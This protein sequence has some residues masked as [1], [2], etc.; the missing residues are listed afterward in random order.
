[1]RILYL[2]Y[3][4]DPKIPVF[5]WQREI[6]IELAKRGHE[7]HVISCQGEPI[8]H[9]DFHSIF[10]IPDR[11]LGLN[12]RTGGALLAN[13]PVLNHVRNLRP[14]VLFCHMA[15]EWTWRLWPTFRRL[16]CPVVQWYAHGTT[17]I[18]LRLAA[19]V[20]DTFLT[21]TESGCRVKHPDIRVI[22]QGI[23]FATF[24]LSDDPP[25]GTFTIGIVGRIS[26]TKRVTESIEACEM[27]SRKLGQPV[28]VFVIGSGMNEIEKRY[29]LKVRE[30]VSKYSSDHFSVQVVGNV[31]RESLAS[32]YQKCHA[33]VNLSSTGSL[34]KTIVEAAAC[35]TPTATSNPAAAQLLERFPE[36]RLHLPQ[37]D[38]LVT[39]LGEVRRKLLLDPLA[40]RSLRNAAEMYSLEHYLDEVERALRGQVVR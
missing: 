26:P 7:M 38:A 25:T 18:N 39:S 17:G 12:R 36:L 40:Y 8:S 24:S 2:T 34:D 23:N 35:G 9:P 20:V 4:V 11:V 31:P 22:G 5:S 27:L 3:S 14:D 29:E 19:R 32:W 33:V 28:R 10:R 30:S 16:S 21:S 37:K 1:M 6:G 13:L 15:A